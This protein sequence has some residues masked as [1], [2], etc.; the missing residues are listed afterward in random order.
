[1]DELI[2]SNIFEINLLKIRLKLKYIKAETIG[3]KYN[4]I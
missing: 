4:W 2:S 1:M 3:F